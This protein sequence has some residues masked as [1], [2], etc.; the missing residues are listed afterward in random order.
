VNPARTADA[1]RVADLIGIGPDH[2]RRAECVNAVHVALLMVGGTAKDMQRAS[3]RKGKP[4]KR[5]AER[6]HKALE[7]LQRALQ[8]PNLPLDLFQI[9]SAVP[10]TAFPHGISLY[11]LARWIEHVNEA[12]TKADKKRYPYKALKKMTA[13]EE[14][15]HLLQQFNKKVSAKK[16]S[17]FCRL[18]ALL[19]GQPR[20]NL[21]WRCREILSS[22]SKVLNQV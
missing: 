4:G 3:Q 19:Y 9:G 11:D 5:A 20:A 22:K 6:L 2:P 10:G 18:A 12:R 8:D 21:Q 7:D 16:G 1:H 15:H 14:A 13:A 17:A